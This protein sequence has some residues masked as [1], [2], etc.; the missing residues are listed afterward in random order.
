MP[1]ATSTLLRL[2]VTARAAIDSEP[3]YERELSAAD[4]PPRVVGSLALAPA[5][6][7]APTPVP[8]QLPGLVPPPPV[9]RRL[10]LVPPPIG[11]LVDRQTDEVFDVVMTARR[12]LPAPAPH[13][14]RLV[15]AILEALTGRRSLTQLVPWLTTEVYDELEVSIDP[16]RIRGFAGR[17]RR[18]IVSEPAD[19]VAEV[20]AVVQRGVR[21]TAI[22][23]RMEGRDG[24]WVITALQT[25]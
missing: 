14:G 12:H 21:T 6:E 16:D 4:G 1:V 15:R 9:R 23:L 20:T 8:A 7:P 24:R 5:L 13:A 22:A 11:R 2:H 17:T 25:A 3:P 19:G 10:E 18:L